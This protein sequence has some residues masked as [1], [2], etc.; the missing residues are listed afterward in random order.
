MHTED[1]AKTKW[2]PHARRI[3]DGYP[4]EQSI[5]VNRDQSDQPVTSCIGS[6]CMAWRWGGAAVRFVDAPTQLE[7]QPTRQ[8]RKLLD[9]GFCGLSGRPE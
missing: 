9:V 7:G 4:V 2:C 8:V 5:S 3:S 1:E 6:A